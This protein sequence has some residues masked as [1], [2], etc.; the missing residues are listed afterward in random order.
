MRN[1]YIG[2]LLLFLLC[3]CF[4]LFH[5]IYIEAKSNAIDALNSRQMIHAKQAQVEIETFFNNIVK[6]LTELSKSEHIID[7]T[8]QGKKDLDLALVLKPE[9]IKAITR[10]DNSGK[11]LHT[12]PFNKEAI[13]KNISNQK[14]VLKILE[15][16]KAVVSDVFMAVQ[17]YR[18]VALHVP[19]FDENEFKGTLGVLID[20][21]SISKRFLQGIKIGET[22]Y[23]W[24]I[25]Q[26]GIELYCPVPGHMG[27]SV[28]ENT[29]EFP[30]I[31]SM[32]KK[33]VR[34]EHGIT[35]Y[36]YNQI[37]D[38]QSETIKKHAVY[39]PINI[40]DNFWTIVVASTEIEILAALV[41]FKNK[42]I[43][44]VGL[45]LLCS[46]IFSYY[47]SKAWGIVKEEKERKNVE[48]ELRLSNQRYQALFHDS[49]A[50]L[51]EE[52]FSELHNYL[53]QLEKNGV[54][55]IREYLDAHPTEVETCA[56]KVKVLDV[57]KATIKLHKAK[58][59]KDLLGNLNNIFTEIS[60]D[61][62]KEEIIALSEGQT[63]FES[64]G[65]VKTITGE[66]K[67]IFLKLVIN[68]ERQKP[69]IALLSTIDITDRKKAEDEL[70][71][72]HKMESIGT[73]AGGVAH[74]FNNILYMIIGNAELALDNL[75]KWNPVHN[76]VEKIKSASIRAAGIVRQLLNFSRK[77]D[78]E[79]KAI[80]AVAVI[81]DGIKFI[82]SSI[83]TTVDIKKQLPEEEITIFGD[84]ILINQVLINICTNASQS[85]EET[86]GVLEI[87]VEK[88]IIEK[89][90][91]IHHELQ[92]GQY[93][94]ISIKDSGTGI[95]ENVID[96]IF[97]PYFTTKEMGKGSG[98]G[99]SI[100]HGIVKNHNG[101]VY[102][103]SHSG[104]GTQFILFFPVIDETPVV[105][106]EKTD[107]T[108][109]G[110]EYILLIDD[111]IEITEMNKRALNKIGYQVKISNNPINALELFRSNPDMFDLIITDM[112]MPQMNGAILSKKLKEIRSDIPVIICTGHS[113]L[114]DDE[115]ADQLNIEGYLMKPVSMSEMANTI[116]SVLDKNPN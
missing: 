100:V 54:Q 36:N 80:N 107:K 81:D 73:L 60:F 88:A 33:M 27:N 52:D 50:P 5:I 59:K 82:R 8:Y 71:Q 38:Q 56:Q 77:T 41:S 86:G 94:K 21:I 37:K 24:M 7:L 99:L 90:S 53:K 35:T 19:V 63:E 72:A 31:I 39:L 112:T 105:Q 89:E 98:M 1:R 66:V 12:T 85:M 95:P 6:F 20:F 17:G 34:G 69:N 111:E 13:G 14:H 103:E 49:P 40:A 22:G 2:C 15:T 75:P 96:R 93:L 62:F 116:R 108:P 30:T 32:A 109:Y 70:R 113:S 25:N 28:F 4:Y 92:N 87:C 29:K 3:F 51:W 67:Y 97:D 48:K 46:G 58:N 78:Q 16:H 61:I 106:M 68:K 79:F 45:L 23:A 83:P 55:N 57:N 42:L 102:V 26:E 64:E 9:G 11:I 76:H 43:I 84:P 115:K 44:V 114:I 104:M 74:D 101:K 110:K 91:Q 65:E 47:L 10:V 18:A